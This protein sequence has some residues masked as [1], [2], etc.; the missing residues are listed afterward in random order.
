[1]LGS[2]NPQAMK[3][4]FA[5]AETYVCAHCFAKSSREILPATAGTERLTFLLLFFPPVASR[6]RGQAPHSD[7]RLAR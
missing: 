4:E 6:K 2:G 5:H 1:M 3:P 7:R